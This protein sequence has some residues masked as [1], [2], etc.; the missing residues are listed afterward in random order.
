MPSGLQASM[1]ARAGDLAHYMLLHDQRVEVASGK[2]PNGTPCTVIMAIGE[3]A[4]VAAE[5]GRRMVAEVEKQR[6]A[7]GEQ[8]REN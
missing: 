2:T 7:R 5:I 1:L 8:A 4:D 3:H 6:R